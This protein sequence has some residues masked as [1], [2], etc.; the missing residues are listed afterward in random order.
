MSK[1]LQ[2][3]PRA[4]E[5][6]VFKE[7]AD[8]LNN[9]GLVV[10]PTETVYGIA[11]N[12]LS[13]KAMARLRKIKE[14]SSEKPF[15]IHV[16]VRQDA[17]KYAVGILPAAY[18]IMH[19]FWP[20]PLTIVLNAPDKKTVGLRMPRNAIALKLL[21]CVDF[22]VVAP[23][24]NLPGHEPSLDAASVA[25]QLGGLVDL[26]IDGGPAELGVPSTVLDARQFPF[27]VLR[28]GCLKQEEIMQVSKMKT[29]LFVCTGNS[30][31]SVMAEYLLRKKMQDR[32]RHDIEVVSCGTFDFF[33]MGASRETQRL[34]QEMGMDAST[35]HAQKVDP[36]FLKRTDLILVMERRHKQEIIRQFP[37]VEARVHLLGDFVKLGWQ[38]PEVDDPIGRSEEFY[39]QVFKKISKAVERLGEML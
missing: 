29:V 36:E 31:R 24:A 8:V 9:D 17:E 20:G 14:R 28:Q 13:V 3:D 5:K 27:T 11:V 33:G 15:T 12:L 21:S 22:P 7:A 4:I 34:I 2:V 32:R 30:C 23:S 37:E 39:G 18:K 38:E 16:A 19:R 10:F 25:D 35:H 1:I 26:I 6:A